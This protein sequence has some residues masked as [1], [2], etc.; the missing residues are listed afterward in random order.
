MTTTPPKKKKRLYTVSKA[1]PLARIAIA[2]AK[3]EKP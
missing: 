2:K 1:A 3:G